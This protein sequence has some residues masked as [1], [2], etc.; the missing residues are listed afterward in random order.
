M[1]PNCEIH[2]SYELGIVG[3]TTIYGESNSTAQKYAV[4]K[5]YSFQI[6]GTQPEPPADPVINDDI[7]NPDDEDPV[8]PSAPQFKDVPSNTYYTQAVA[9]AVEKGITSGIGGGRFGPENACTRGQIVTFLWRATGSPEPKTAV[10]PFND[11][12]ATDYY[13][14]A[15]LWA[16][17]NNITSSGVGKDKFGPGNP[18]TRGQAVTFLWRAAGSPGT[19]STG[20]L[21]TD[22]KAGSYYESAVK[23]AVVNKVASGTSATTFS[24]EQSCTRGQIVTFLYRADS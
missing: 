1:N 7:R 22:V 12:K 11:V 17:E 5:G 6:L 10:N 24:P 18:C 4:D 9:W 19:D 15:V 14:K 13:Y 8:D 20:K 23:W 2:S 21:F 3:K 16:V